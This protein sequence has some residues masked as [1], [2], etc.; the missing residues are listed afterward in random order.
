MYSGALLMHM[1]NFAPVVEGPNPTSVNVIVLFWI[2]PPLTTHSPQL[3][4]HISVESQSDKEPHLLGTWATDHVF[5]ESKSSTKA[6]VWQTNRV[7]LKATP[8]EAGI[9]GI[10]QYTL[11][12]VVGKNSPGTAQRLSK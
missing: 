3:R 2:T 1:K 10:C 7:G 6:F 8:F 9:F 12:G 4:C 5:I 11:A